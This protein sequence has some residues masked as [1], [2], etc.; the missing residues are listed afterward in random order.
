M[1]TAFFS[2]TTLLML[3]TI[4]LVFMWVPT[5]QNLGISQ[6][7]F[8]FHVP[9]GWIG[10]V[11]IFVVGIASVMHLSTRNDKWDSIAYSAAELG[12]IFATLILVT[13]A[14]WAK[15][16]WGVWWTW[17][18]KLTTT[19]ILWFIYVGYL[20]VRTYAPKGS[21]GRRYSSAVALLGALDAP[22]IYMASIWWRTAHPDLN[23][24]PLADSG[25]LDS[26]MQLTFWIAF[27]AFTVFYI[28]I[29][30]ERIAM[31]RAE[32]ALDEVH[33]YVASSG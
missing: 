33:Q 28:Y 29:L 4:Y 5:E 6:R 25:G 3:V 16:V 14:I 13:G 18:P 24:G 20:M 22:L 31:R 30:V 2:L 27:I 17:D 15:P 26:N 32:D 1:R 19:L 21:R 11:S 12:L 23:I 8:Y 9:L 10:M 7:I